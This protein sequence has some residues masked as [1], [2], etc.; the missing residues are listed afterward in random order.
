MK[1]LI[2]IILSLVFFPAHANPQD[3]AQIFIP[4]KLSEG[5]SLKANGYRFEIVR[6]E[7]NTSLIARSPAGKEETVKLGK[8]GFSKIERLFYLESHGCG[9]ESIDIVIQVGPEANDEIIR[10][11]Y[12]R[13]IFSREITKVISKFFDP[14]VDAANAVLPIQTVEGL[15]SSESKDFISCNGSR[16][17]VK[18]K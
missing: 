12:Y 18:H 13:I 10:R 4:E 5:M 11:S 2:S 14:S 1:I 15:V 7:E 3:G 16:P 8:A 17:I 9:S 6:D